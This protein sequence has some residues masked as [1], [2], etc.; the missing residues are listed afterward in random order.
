MLKLQY[1]GHLMQKLTHLKTPWCWGSLKAGGEED[2]RGWDGWMASPTQWTWICVN[3][4]CWWWTGRPG[5]LQ[6]MGSQRVRHNWMTELN[7]PIMKYCHDYLLDTHSDQPS[8]FCEGPRSVP[9]FVL[10]WISVLL[11][12]D[13]VIFIHC[14]HDGP[15]L[16]WL[17]AFQLLWLDSSF[18]RSSH[19]RIYF[20][21]FAA[22]IYLHCLLWLLYWVQP[23]FQASQVALVVKN[24]PANDMGS[25]RPPGGGHVNPLQYSCLE[26]PMD[27]ET[28][29]ATVHLV[30]QSWT[31]SKRVSRHAHKP[32]FH[33]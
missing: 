24:P 5:M 21:D 32:H 11:G 30:A 1:F 23:H 4:G 17:L 8:G 29:W 33:C 10:S 31:W 12:F 25:G 14:Y 15:F 16:V 27:R 7:L 9:G 2:D 6:S 13:L 18:I 3:S 19:F 22:Y 26:N 20:L 28:W